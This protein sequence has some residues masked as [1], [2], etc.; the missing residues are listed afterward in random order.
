MRHTEERKCRMRPHE[1]LWDDVLALDR[2]WGDEGDTAA[3]S[4]AL[5][6]ALRVQR[7]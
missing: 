5:L 3:L 1:A 2:G 4:C 6:T 7:L